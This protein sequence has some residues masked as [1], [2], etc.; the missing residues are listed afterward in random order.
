MH[1]HRRVLV[2]VEPGAAHTCV[3]QRETERLHQMQ[4]RPGVSAQA[5]DVA[6]VGRDF[7]FDQNDVNHAAQIMLLRAQISRRD[8]VGGLAEHEPAR[9]RPREPRPLRTQREPTHLT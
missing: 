2:V 7:R 6:G 3:V 1:L 8:H 4:H 5:N 9:R